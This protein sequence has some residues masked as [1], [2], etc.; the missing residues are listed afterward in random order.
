M[1]GGVS[2]DFQRGYACALYFTWKCAGLPD[3]AATIA[4]E[5]LVTGQ[6]ASDETAAWTARHAGLTK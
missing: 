3:T 2:G 4:C 1:R 6:S 5:A